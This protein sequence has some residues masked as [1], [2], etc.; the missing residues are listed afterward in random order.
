MKRFKNILVAID[1]RFDSHPIVDE[2]VEIALHNGASLKIVDVTPEFPWIARLTMKDYEHMRE[3]ITKEK[4]E[5]LDSL[6][7]PIREKE[8]AVETRVLHGKTSVE[9]IREVLR[10]D[11]DLVLRVNKGQGSRRQGFFGNT[12]IRLLRKCPC[13]VWLV[14]PDKTKFQHVLG[15]IDTSTG[16]E[17][18]AELNEEVFDL[19]KTISHYHSGDFSILQTWSVMSEQFLGR[20]MEHDAFDKMVLSNRDQT[21][22]LLDKF[23]RKHDSNV[24]A[25]NVHLIKGEAA[26][27]ISRFI[28][29]N[30]VDLVVMGTV[31]RSGVSGVVMGNTAEQIIS[32]MEC[33][34]LALKPSNFVS[35]I[36]MED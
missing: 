30:D 32:D 6:V 1:T 34:V 36:Q 18:D 4:Q 27:G 3:L 16:E 5:A 15:C 31:A 14:K 11:H 7:G 35:P 29:D 17:L 2:A 23:L 26:D 12:G 20:R 22:K 9:I 25:A 28:H 33:S 13:P 10:A 24:D 19:A 8:I 21:K